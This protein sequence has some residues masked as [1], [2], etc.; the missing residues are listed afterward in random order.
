MYCA[1]I[2]VRKIIVN[3]IIITRQF[4][5]MYYVFQCNECYKRATSHVPYA[6]I[7]IKIFDY[8]LILPNMKS[9]KEYFIRNMCQ[10]SS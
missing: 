8:R 9:I 6:W 3:G 4:F 1:I 2:I 5:D 7:V 10:K